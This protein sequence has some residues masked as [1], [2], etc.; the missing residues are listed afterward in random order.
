MPLLVTSHFLRPQ[1]ETKI[2]KSGPQ[3]LPKIT[4]HTLVLLG[5]SRERQPVILVTS[6]IEENRYADPALM[7]LI[8]A[9]RGD[10]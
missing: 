6:S 8:L 10:K 3:V 2:S 1:R 7:L 5:I 9:I 4:L